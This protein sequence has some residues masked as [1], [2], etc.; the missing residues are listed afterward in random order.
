L[1]I[2]LTKD[3]AWEVLA[4]AQTGI[5]TTLKADGTPVALPVW[6]VALDERIYVATP[7]HTKKV[8]RVTRNSRASFLV[9]SGTRWVD[10]LGVHLTGEAR[11]VTD[12]DRVARV[13]T[14]LDEKYSGFRSSARRDYNPAIT[15]LEFKPDDRILTWGNSRLGL[16]D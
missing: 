7:S 12:D 11:V 13:R 14:A 5:F 15:V 6:F 8:A 3:E 2:R 4:G 1:S 9:E 10:L 16:S